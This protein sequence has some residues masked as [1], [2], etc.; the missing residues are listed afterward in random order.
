MP[1]SQT[2]FRHS[3]QSSIASGKSSRLYPVFVQSCRPTPARLCEGVD[4]EFVLTSPAVSR[5]S[6]S[7]NLDSFRDG[8]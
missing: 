6:C 7:S 3:S 1:I 8:K 4:Y 5:M 2:P